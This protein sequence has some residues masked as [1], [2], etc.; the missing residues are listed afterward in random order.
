MIFGFLIGMI[1]SVY[2]MKKDFPAE[3]QRGYE[4]YNQILDRDID[5]QVG[6]KNYKCIDLTE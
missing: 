1:G 2:F 5:M 3:V 6:N 4:R